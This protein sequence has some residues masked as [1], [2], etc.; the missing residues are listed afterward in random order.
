MTQHGNCL[1]ATA[2]LM[3]LAAEELTPD[4]LDAQDPRYPVQVTIA[5]RTPAAIS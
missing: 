2:A 5:C 4:E 1:A 3:G